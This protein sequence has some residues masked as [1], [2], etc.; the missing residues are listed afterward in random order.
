MTSQ[1][2]TLMYVEDHGVLYLSGNMV[3][4]DQYGVPHIEPIDWEQLGSGVY[5]ERKPG[6]RDE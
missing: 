2:E 1:I 3:M 5:R 6:G 4:I